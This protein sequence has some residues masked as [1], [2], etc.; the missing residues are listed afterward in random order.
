MIMV[1]H[2][3]PWTFLALEIHVTSCGVVSICVGDRS[4]VTSQSPQFMLTTLIEE[5]RLAIQ[6]CMQK[7]GSVGMGIPEF[8]AI[9]VALR[10]YPSLNTPDMLVA[11][12]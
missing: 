10:K 9:R 5:L 12:P 7:D 3:K 6:E 11:T 8:E 2:H 1:D 4:H